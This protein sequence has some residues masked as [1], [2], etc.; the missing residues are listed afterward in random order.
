MYTNQLIKLEA[1]VGKEY[2]LKSELI[3]DGFKKNLKEK[4]ESQAFSY[5]HANRISEL[6]GLHRFQA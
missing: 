3:P 6:S 2:F 1:L 4:T 5:A